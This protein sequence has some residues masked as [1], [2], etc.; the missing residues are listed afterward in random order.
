MLLQLFQSCIVNIHLNELE[1]GCQILPVLVNSVHCL[2]MSLPT[3]CWIIWRVWWHSDIVK[4]VITSAQGKKRCQLKNHD[5]EHKHYIN[6]YTDMHLQYCVRITNTHVKNLLA[7]LYLRLKLT[8]CTLLSYTLD[9]SIKTDA[10]NDIPG[11]DVIIT[12]HQQKFCAI[13]N[14]QSRATSMFTHNYLLIYRRS[15]SHKPNIRW[16]EFYKFLSASSKLSFQLY[17]SL[18]PRPCMQ[19]VYI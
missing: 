15:E 18:L 14:P 5:L 3:W 2:K 11:S 12:L 13:W 6:F 16:T 17:R 4:S 9:I 10:Q 7:L 19:D 8:V 1:C